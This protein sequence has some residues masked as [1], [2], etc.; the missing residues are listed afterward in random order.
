MAPIRYW[1]DV[2]IHGRRNSISF[3]GFNE[4]SAREDRALRDCTRLVINVQNMFSSDKI[5]DE[6][7]TCVAEAG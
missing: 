6:S 3:P 7:K 1:Q 5:L 4:G 2:L